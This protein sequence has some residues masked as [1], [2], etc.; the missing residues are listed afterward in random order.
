MNVGFITAR[1][2][3]Y[4]GFQDGFSVGFRYIYSKI[5]T[6]KNSK[7]ICNFVRQYHLKHHH[8]NELQ[9]FYLFTIYNFKRLLQRQIEEHKFL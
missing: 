2:D 9:T 6:R 3:D 5:G 1:F 8:F 4:K 7:K